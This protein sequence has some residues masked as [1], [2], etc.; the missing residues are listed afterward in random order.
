M[1]K[2]DHNAVPKRSETLTRN[3]IC[4]IVSCGFISACGPSPRAGLV[5]DVPNS[6]FDVYGLNISD[7]DQYLPKSNGRY[8]LEVGRNSSGTQIELRFSDGSGESLH[9]LNRDGLRRFPLPSPFAYL[10]ADRQPVV[11]F[12]NY[13]NR[14]YPTASFPSD[15]TFQITKTGFFGVDRQGEYF[16]YEPEEN[17]GA[18]RIAKSGQPSKTLLETADIRSNYE[19][20][21]IY[22]GANKIYIARVRR[23]DL[24]FSPIQ[25]RY[26]VFDAN[27]EQDVVL[28]KARDVAGPEGREEFS[29]GEIDMEPASGLLLVELECRGLF[30]SNTWYLN[31]LN[32]DTYQFIGNAREHG[33][34][35]TSDILKEYEASRDKQIDFEFIGTALLL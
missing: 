11:S 1:V 14:K 12:D 26:A 17:P 13:T 35:L 33:M 18:I 32:R 25:L 27:D 29:F 30:R 16:I 19:W 20:W 6:E 8:N 24:K 9:V 22:S 21:E 5:Y 15:P 34:F 2:R 23:S 4:A 28:V 7:I 31:D 3:V 10:D